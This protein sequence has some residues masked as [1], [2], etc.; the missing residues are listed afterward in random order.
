MPNNN[1]YFTVEEINIIA[2]YKADT[3]TATVE[4]IIAAC[5]DILDEDIITIAETASYKLAALSDSEFAALSFIPVDETEAE[6]DEVDGQHTNATGEASTANTET[7]AT[8]GEGG[9]YV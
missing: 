1:F 2:I 4:R 5:D 9:E 7:P 8:P 3:V 6:P